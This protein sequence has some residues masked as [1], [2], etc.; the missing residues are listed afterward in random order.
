MSEGFHLDHFKVFL[1]L[2]ILSPKPQRAAACPVQPKLSSQF[3]SGH[4]SSDQFS[5]IQF[6]SVCFTWEWLTLLTARSHLL[7]IACAPTGLMFHLQG[8][9]EAEEDL[10]DSGV[11]KCNNSRV[12]NMRISRKSAFRNNRGK[13]VFF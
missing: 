2:N 7:S 1:C 3:S 4:S 8:D 13:S 12:S 11:W 6:N 10:Q 5:S 9:R